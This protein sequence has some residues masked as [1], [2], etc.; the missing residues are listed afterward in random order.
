MRIWDVYI[1]HAL[2]IL[3]TVKL[4]HKWG[5]SWDSCEAEQETSDAV[6]PARN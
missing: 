3:F 5:V 1:F 6:R 4:F 2:L